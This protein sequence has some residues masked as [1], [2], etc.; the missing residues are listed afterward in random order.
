MSL[1]TRKIGKTDVC[2]IGY[3]AMGIS[4]AY[5]DP[6]PD[7][8]RFKLLD[9]VYERGCT[10][11]DTSDAY[12]DSE[13]VLGKWCVYFC[14]IFYGHCSYPTLRFKRT[15]KRNDIFLA[16]KF[17]FVPGDRIING[18]A[19][20][21]RVAVERSLS[22]LGVDCI[23]LYYLHRPDPTV[24]I[25]ISVGAMAE[26][27]KYVPWIVRIQSLTWCS[28]PQGR[29]SQI[30]RSVGVLCRDSSTRAQSPSYCSPTNRI[31]AVRFRH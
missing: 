31:F 14:S 20:H 15:G 7:Q 23:D 19:E 29:E 16:T 3:G 5:G 13:E 27:V 24:P 8:E 28:L 9:A 11:W 18:T 30:S 10:H 26:F 1:P 6:L 12:A 4:I 25:E 2:A 22:R 17:G 21:A